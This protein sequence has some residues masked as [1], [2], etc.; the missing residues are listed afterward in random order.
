MTGACDFVLLAVWSHYHRATAFYPLEPKTAQPQQALVVF[1]ELFRDAPQ[2]MAADFN[3]NVQ[4]DR[5]GRLSNWT[6]TVEKLHDAGLVSAYHLY[7]DVPFGSELHPTLYWRDRKIDGPRYHIDCCF[8][9]REWQIDG[10]TIGTFDDWVGSGLS[11]HV[12]L[13]VDVAM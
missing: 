6:V 12:P 4:W 13:I 7:F 10:V 9:P 1:E 3:S 2:V 11:D 5:P 8:V